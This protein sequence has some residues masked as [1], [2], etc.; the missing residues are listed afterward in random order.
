M[1]ANRSNGKTIE[2]KGGTLQAMTAI[3]RDPNVMKL[4]DAMHAMLGGMGEF[5]AGEPTVLDLTGTSLPERMDWSGIA[6]L[7]RRYGLQPVAVRGIPEAHGD[8]ARKAGLAVLSGDLRNAPAAGANQP[9]PA[10]APVASKADP[11]STPASANRSM[12]IDRPLRSGQQIYARGCDL[13]VVGGVSNGAEIIADG[14]IHCYGPLRGR[15]IA[16]A[17][18]D[19]KARIFTTSL[20]AELVSIAGVFRTFERGLPEEVAGRAAQITLT[21]E[22]DKAQL[23]LD[24]LQLG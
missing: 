17:Q 20:G 5:F 14:N 13:I 3:V 12:V 6:S 19:Q 4:A 7:L 11:E 22:G 16:G 9:E 2:F 10:A 24:P 15:A 1:Q 21:G 23:R 8:G 18:G